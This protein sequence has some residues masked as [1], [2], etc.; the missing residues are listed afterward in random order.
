MEWD[1][2]W[3]LNKKNLDPIAPKLTA[4]SKEGA[5]SVE[6]ENYSEIDQATTDFPLHPK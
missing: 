3:A 2:I 6:V 4:I 5:I 1:K